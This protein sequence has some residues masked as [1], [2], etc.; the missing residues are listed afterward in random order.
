MFCLACSSSFC[1]I[2]MLEFSV[3]RMPYLSCRFFC[4]S[5]MRLAF[6]TFYHFCKPTVSRDTSSEKSHMDEIFNRLLSSFF[7]RATWHHKQLFAFLFVLP[8]FSFVFSDSPVVSKFSFLCCRRYRRNRE[9]I[10]LANF[11]KSLFFP[12]RLYFSKK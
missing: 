6:C 5:C 12:D 10:N 4:I 11:I 8:L 1:R 7:H 9:S 2:W 3:Y